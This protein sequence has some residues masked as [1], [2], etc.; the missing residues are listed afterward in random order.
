MVS[1]EEI[2]LLAEMEHTRW[3]AERVLA[4]W[5]YA[6]KPKNETRR[7]N[8]NLIPW[9]DLEGTI[10]KYDRDAVTAIPG[11]VSEVKGMKICHT[12]G[13]PVRGSGSHLLEV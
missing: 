8:P 6:V 3:V 10:K 12:G 7:T 2:E 1:T 4:G 11:L 13:T 5:T 9:A